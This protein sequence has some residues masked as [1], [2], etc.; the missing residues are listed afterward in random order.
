MTDNQRRV[1]TL[2][3]TGTLSTVVLS[4]ASIDADPVFDQPVPDI[5][6][7]TPTALVGLG[8][9]DLSVFDTD[10]TL[11]TTIETEGIPVHLALSN[12]ETTAAA[13][14]RALLADESTPARVVLEEAT[15][16]RDTLEAEYP[17][18][19]TM[20]IG[21]QVAVA[22][23]DGGVKRVLAY[24]TVPRPEAADVV[25]SITKAG[26]EVHI[27]SGDRDHVLRAVAAELSIP[28]D[29]IH[30]DASAAD[31]ARTIRA[32]QADGASTVVMVGDYVNDREA[33]AA[34]DRAILVGADPP[35]SLK[36]MV[37]T[38]TPSLAE[39]PD[40]L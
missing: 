6:A 2:D 19:A 18:Y 36:S 15:A 4:V 34:A 3:N 32:L 12:G 25:R 30:A 33:F 5:P 8:V 37:D 10:Q 26:W 22:L 23:P 35:S 29:C 39:V 9:T 17:A 20:P 31:K 1:V 38:V 40:L 27:V 28:E 13:A 16:L 11:G 21:V 24:T 7:D 14:R